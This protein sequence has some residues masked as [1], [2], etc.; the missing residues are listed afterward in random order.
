MGRRELP[1]GLREGR[2]RDGGIWVAAHAKVLALVAHF[3]D[4]TRPAPTQ[5][6]RIDPDPKAANRVQQ[7]YLDLGT[8][9]SAG[10][11]GAVHDKQLLIGSITERKIQVC[12]RAG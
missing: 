7:V 1:N 11:I 8:Q 6:L 4:E 12:E 10:S 3:G 2:R 5:I 9:L